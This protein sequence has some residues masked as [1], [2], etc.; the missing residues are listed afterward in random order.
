MLALWFI[1]YAVEQSHGFLAAGLLFILPAV[2]GM[3]FSA[4][5]LPEFISVGASGG[6]TFFPTKIYPFV[7][8]YSSSSA[9]QLDW[10]SIAIFYSRYLWLDWS[11]SSRY[12]KQLGLTL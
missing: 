9:H 6:K 3:L 8:D 10:I 5:F 1:G 11:M 7:R 2:G 12:N 4:L